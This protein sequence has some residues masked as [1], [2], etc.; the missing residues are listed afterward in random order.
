MTREEQ[1]RQET[2]KEVIEFLPFCKWLKEQLVA[3]VRRREA[4]ENMCAAFME[5][6]NRGIIPIILEM[7]EY[8]KWIAKVTNGG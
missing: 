7:P 2:G 1:Y 6:V 5:S 8:K 4:A 3:E